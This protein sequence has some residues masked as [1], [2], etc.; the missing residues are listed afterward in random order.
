MS[1]ARVAQLGVVAWLACG[2]AGAA[3][4]A[5]SPEPEQAPVPTAKLYQL[6]VVEPGYDVTIRETERGPAHSLIE[7]ENTVVPPHFTA[8]TVVLFKAVYDIAKERG[9]EYAFMNERTASSP[10]P[11]DG[12]RITAA[13]FMT[14]DRKTPLRELLGADYS[15][16]AQRRFDREGWMSVT[17][18]A[19]MFGEGGNRG[20]GVSDPLTDLI[21]V[22]SHMPGGEPTYRVSKKGPNYFI[23]GRAAAGW[24]TPIRL[25]ALTESQ[26][27]EAAAEGLRFSAGL[28]TNQGSADQQFD[29]LRIEEAVPG[30]GGRTATFYVLFSWFGPDLLY[31]LP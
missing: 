30:S 18:L 16:E 25:V 14:K 20:G 26:R 21:G 22:Y 15:P 23:E 3:R 19:R 1:R 6:K 13:V 31:K 8:G 11:N 5:G 12:R 4:V 28:R 7:I 2:W 27:A 17:Q 24:R 9:F 29:I 10:P